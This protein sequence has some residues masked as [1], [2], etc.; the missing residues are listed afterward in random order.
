MA[1]G[2]ASVVLGLNGLESWG[3]V[4]IAGLVCAILSMNFKKKADAEGMGESGF[5][6]AG[7]ITGTI[8]LILSIIGI[9]GGLICGICVCVAG[10]AGVLSGALSNAGY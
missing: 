2:I 4:G 9:V 10:G 1:L 7:K 3:I 8:G 6:K 5:A